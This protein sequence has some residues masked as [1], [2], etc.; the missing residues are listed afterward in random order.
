MKVRYLHGKIFYRWVNRQAG[1]SQQRS[2]QQAMGDIT[3]LACA[4]SS[5]KTAL[6]GHVE[7]INSTPRTREFT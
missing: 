4:K 6:S 5:K 7:R 1:L 3:L 2:I